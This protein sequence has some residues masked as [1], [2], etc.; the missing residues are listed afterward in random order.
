MSVLLDTSNWLLYV[1]TI[2]LGIGIGIGEYLGIHKVL[3]LFLGGVGFFVLYFYFRNE[4]P[5]H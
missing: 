5:A 3:L 1:L 2:T 4:Q